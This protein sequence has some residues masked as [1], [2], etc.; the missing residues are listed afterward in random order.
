M[1]IAISIPDPIFQSAE[2]LARQLGLSR[3]ELYSHAIA[4]FISAY[5][6]DLTTNALNAVYTGDESALDPLDWQMQMVTLRKVEW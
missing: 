5:H 2:R 3:S 4:D 1:Q 6:D